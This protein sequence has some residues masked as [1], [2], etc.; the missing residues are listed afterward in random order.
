MTGYQ[1]LKQMYETA[2]KALWSMATSNP[3]EWPKLAKQAKEAIEELE[4][5][6]NG[7]EK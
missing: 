7:K 5:I 2:Y 1:K 3:G 4:R 6:K